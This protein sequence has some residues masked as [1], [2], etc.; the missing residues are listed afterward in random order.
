[1]TNKTKFELTIMHPGG[2]TFTR[3][4]IAE[5]N[6]YDEGVYHFYDGTL[7][8]D[9]KTVACYPTSCT[10]VESETKINWPAPESESELLL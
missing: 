8:I 6:V 9:H 1:M 10:I 3:T 7:N 4:V 2:G 5:H